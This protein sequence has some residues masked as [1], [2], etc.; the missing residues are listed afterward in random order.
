MP[1]SLV[2]GPRRRRVLR[3]SSIQSAVNGRPVYLRWRGTLRVFTVRLA[4]ADVLRVF[5]SDASRAIIEQRRYVVGSL[6]EAGCGLRKSM[7]PNHLGTAARQ[8]P[9]AIP[10]VGEKNCRGTPGAERRA[11]LKESVCPHFAVFPTKNPED[12]HVTLGREESSLAPA[13]AS[14][15]F[16]THRVNPLLTRM[17]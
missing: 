13:G 16:H 4:H 7:L 2:L 12:K 17:L 10:P 11:H 3:H 14:P 9:K 8:P 1:S 15:V 6:K 5:A